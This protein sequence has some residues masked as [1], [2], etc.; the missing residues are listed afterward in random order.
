MEVQE[1]ILLN[2]DEQFKKYGIRAVTMDEI[3]QNCG[4]SKKTIYQYFKDK[5]DLVDAVMMA[6]FADNLKKCKT[7]SSESK[8]AIEEIFMLMESIGEDF[9]SIN[10]II[11]LD[12]RKF[13]VVT[14]QKFQKHIDQTITQMVLENIE[15]GIKEG[16]YRRNLHKEIVARFRMA[17]IWI[18]FDQDIFP[19]PK[20]ELSNVFKEVLELFLYGLV[21][22]K[23]YQ[24]IEKYQQQ[25]NKK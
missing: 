9:R 2:A 24:L 1:R 22:P 5:N 6:H 17:S 4:T 14:F 19:Y 10:P 11:L 13:H 21:S 23:G 20:F 7:C 15:R 16:L 12:L 8:N 18:L 25:N 3:A